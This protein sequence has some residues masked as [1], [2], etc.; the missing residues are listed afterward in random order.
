VKRVRVAHRELIIVLEQA[1][2]AEWP[3]YRKK[4]VSGPTETPDGLPQWNL[5]PIFN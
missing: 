1:R 3:F 5:I 2:E 4:A